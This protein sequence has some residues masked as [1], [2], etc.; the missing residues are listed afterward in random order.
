MLCGGD[1][2]LGS[3]VVYRMVGVVPLLCFFVK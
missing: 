2:G 3:G 1:S